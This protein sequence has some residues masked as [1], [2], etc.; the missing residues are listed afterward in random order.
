M[1]I[2]SKS[3]PCLGRFSSFMEGNVSSVFNGSKQVVQ[4]WND[5]TLEIMTVFSFL[6]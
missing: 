1:L 3:P 5:M 2:L 6:G 4:V